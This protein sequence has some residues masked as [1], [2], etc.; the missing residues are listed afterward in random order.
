MHGMP[1]TRDPKKL[2]LTLVLTIVVLDACVIGLYYAFHIQAR[3]VKTQQTFVAVWVVLT[4]LVVT[5]LMKRIRDAR[6]RR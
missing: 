6:R 5:T 1:G 2:L 4:L 3:A